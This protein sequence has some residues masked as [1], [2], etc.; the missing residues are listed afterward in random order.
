MQLPAGDINIKSANKSIIFVV[1]NHRVLKDKAV[2]VIY[3]ISIF[4]LFSSLRFCQIRLYTLPRKQP[5]NVIM[6]M[7]FAFDFPDLIYLA[8][9]QKPYILIDWSHPSI[10]RTLSLSQIKW[11][12]GFDSQ[13]GRTKI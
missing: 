8:I 10:G 7:L 1:K 6:S 2:F 9:L 5:Y 12:F 13:I 4:H 3:T 11:V